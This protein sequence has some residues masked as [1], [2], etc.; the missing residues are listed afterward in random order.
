MEKSLIFMIMK[1]KACLSL[2]VSLKMAHA[3]YQMNSGNF[4]L[5]VV[6]GTMAVCWPTVKLLMAGVLG[7]TAQ[8][9]FSV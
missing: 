8:R 7:L 5:R 3:G 4:G 6:L 2:A 1:K 9:L